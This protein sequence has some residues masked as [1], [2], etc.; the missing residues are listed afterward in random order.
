MIESG[1][2]R[3]EYG[4]TVLAACFINDLGTVLALGLIFAPFTW[5]TLIFAG[6]A[7]AVFAVLPWLTPR[8]YPRVRQSPFG[9]G[10]KIPAALP[11]RR[12]RAGGLGRQRGGAAGLPDRHGARRHRWHAITRW[13]G[14]CAP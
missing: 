7:I 6:V 2:N 1:L 5:Q 12:G 10:S 8:F 3:T 11:V 4:K 9:T 14:G 13:S